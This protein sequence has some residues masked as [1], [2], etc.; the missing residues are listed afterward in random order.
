M[1]MVLQCDMFKTQ[2]PKT[3]IFRF[4]VIK[5]LEYSDLLICIHSLIQ[6]NKGQSVSSKPV[7]SFC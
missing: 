5:S 1:L 7:V 6:Q 2:L 4:Y 3:I